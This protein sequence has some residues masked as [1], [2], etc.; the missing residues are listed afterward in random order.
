MWDFCSSA[1]SWIC[2]PC[3][4]RQVLTSGPPGKSSNL[5][6]LGICLLRSYSL[7]PRVPPG[8]NIWSRNSTKQKFVF[9]YWDIGEI[10]TYTWVH[11]CGL[12]YFSH[13]QLFETPQTIAHQPPL[14]MGFSRQEHWSG[15]LHPSPG[16]L[17]D[18]EIKPSSLTSP[19]LA[20]G[21]FLSLSHQG[22]PSCWL[23]ILN[24]TVVSWFLYV[25]SSFPRCLF[26]LSS[27]NYWNLPSSS[28]FRLPYGFFP[29]FLLALS[30]VCRGC[31]DG[32]GVA[33]TLCYS[34]VY[35]FK[36]IS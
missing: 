17:P 11:T 12:S 7:R 27:S 26:S 16:N 8:P 5:F 23:S 22:S 21:C 9:T 33:F 20:G 10:L 28:V 34:L 6:N 30:W 1:R 13:I 3:I 15:L 36:F 24:I 4:G 25:V 2:T 18:P 14:S 31:C 32:G 19:A 35:F 29:S